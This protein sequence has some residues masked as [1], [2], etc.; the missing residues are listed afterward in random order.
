[1]TRGRT[2]SAAPAPAPMSEP[3][4]VD[5]TR[6]TI[7]DIK[8]FASMAQLAKENANGDAEALLLLPG[9]IDMLDRVVVGGVS[10]RPL[11]EL[12][13]IVGELNLQLTKAGNP[14]N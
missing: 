3:V 14:K 2:A 13:S 1:M 5:M 8:V 12:W 6:L 11:S 4:V 7:G 10:H 9:L